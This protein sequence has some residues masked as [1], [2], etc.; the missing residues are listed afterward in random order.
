MAIHLNISK[1]NDPKIKITRP[2]LSGASPRDINDQLEL[3][4]YCGIGN[5]CGTN[6][7][8]FFNVFNIRF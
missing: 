2:L 5:Y 7:C 3:K 8:G 1:E 4:H 6:V